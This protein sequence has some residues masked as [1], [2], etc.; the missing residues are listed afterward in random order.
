MFPSWC[1]SHL[2]WST[3]LR[4]KI[5]LW[6]RFFSFGFLAKQM[7]SPSSSKVMFHSRMEML[8]LFEEPT[9]STRSWYTLTLGSTPSM[10][11]TAS[12]NYAYTQT[13]RETVIHF[14]IHVQ[15]TPFS[16]CYLSMLLMCACICMCVVHCTFS[17]VPLSL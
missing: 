5:A 12:H 1:M 10:G 9:N 4:V 3:T 7:Y 15:E 6:L 13:Y 8:L 14:H 2:P 11:I 17:M 16:I